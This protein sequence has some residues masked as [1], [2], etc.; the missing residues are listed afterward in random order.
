MEIWLSMKKN[1]LYN[2]KQ[3]YDQNGNQQGYE[4]K[5][6]LITDMTN[7]TQT[8]IKQAQKN[9]MI[10]ISVMTYLMHEEI[11]LG[12]IDIMTFIKNGNTQKAHTNWHIKFVNT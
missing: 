10:F 9:E 3:T 8:V 11:N 1:D 5:T 2:R 12:I 4:K 6:T 7:T